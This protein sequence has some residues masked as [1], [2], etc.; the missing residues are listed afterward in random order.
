MTQEQQGIRRGNAE[1]W[2]CLKNVNEIRL[3]G[4]NWDPRRNIERACESCEKE[5]G[6][7]E[8][9]EGEYQG[10][11]FQIDRA[12]SSSPS[13]CRTMTSGR[14]KAMASK[15]KRL[16]GARERKGRDPCVQQF[17]PAEED[18]LEQPLRQE[19]LREERE[20]IIAN[21]QTIIEGKE[22]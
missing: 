4:N 7:E 21:E 11:Q 14:V 3:M 1:S 12:R 22:A 20:L 9:S 18:I 15:S 5:L 16:V 2:C 17:R 19:T 10:A 6:G 13:I 8:Y